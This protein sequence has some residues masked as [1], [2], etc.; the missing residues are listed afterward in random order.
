MEISKLIRN[1]FF[2]YPLFGT[3]I[4]NTNFTLT[5]EHVPAPAFT[6]GKTIYYKE[7]L[8]TDYSEE[9][10]EFIIAHEILHIALRHIFRNSGKDPDLL[11]YV[12]DA[13]INQLLVQNGQK[14]PEGLVDV[15]YAL[16]YSVD[17]L[18]MKFLPNLKEI[19]EWMGANTFH[20]LLNMMDELLNDSLEKSYNMDLQ[21]LMNENNTL[22]SELLDSYKEELKREQENFN[23]G[24]DGTYSQE[25]P[26]VPVGKS[27]PLI[28]WDNLLK[29]NVVLSKEPMTSF[30]EVQADG[31]IKKEEKPTDDDISSEILVDS[32]GSMQMRKIV[33]IL[34]EC[35]N[36]LSIGSIKV[37]FFDTQFYGW[38]EINNESDI[39]NLKIIGRGG[40]NFTLMAETFSPEVDNKIIITDGQGMFP[41]N[42]PEVIWLVINRQMP[43][44][45]WIPDPKNTNIIFI[46]E[47]Q[48][49][50]DKPVKS[51]YS[52]QLKPIV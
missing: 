48:V 32:S 21:E 29:A 11:N 25:F 51:V 18:Y 34:R 50:D 36:I 7:E 41:Y 16:D 43:S 3:I 31:I 10:V 42:R 23:I 40:T 2:R 27:K 47:K 5:K 15:P 38:H 12:E 24:G 13:I 14:M 30:Y 52:K 22:R 28:F 6:D 44:Q 8:F 39:D 45:N 1:V 35:K 20:I 49:F 4:V 37:G 19:K 17:E 46:D 26:S 9:E 33:E